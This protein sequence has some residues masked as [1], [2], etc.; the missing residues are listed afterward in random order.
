[1]VRIGDVGE[2][3]R[4]RDKFKAV[5]YARSSRGAGVGLG[6]FKWLWGEFNVPTFAISKQNNDRLMPW[7]YVI[8][9]MNRYCY[10]IAYRSSWY[11]GCLQSLAICHAQ[12]AKFE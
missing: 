5:G 11:T 7:V 12:M 8:F 9:Q 4:G 1:M 3:S 2:R 6:T 10:A